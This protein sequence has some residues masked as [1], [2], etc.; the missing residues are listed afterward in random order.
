MVD[1]E[2]MV[3][4]GGVGYYWGG[5][6]SVPCFLKLTRCKGNLTFMA[7]YLVARDLERA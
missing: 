2:G 3:L 6:V 4:D 5:T 7:G 1:Q